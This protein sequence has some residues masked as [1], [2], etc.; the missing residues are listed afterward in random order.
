MSPHRADHIPEVVLLLSLPVLQ[1]PEV[2]LLLSQP[3][4]H[5]ALLNGVCD[6]VILGRLRVC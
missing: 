1:L 3:V 4:L 6:T 2:A 5:V